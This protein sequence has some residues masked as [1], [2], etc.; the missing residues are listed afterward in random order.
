MGVP[1]N[2]YT[3]SHSDQLVATLAKQPVS[4]FETHYTKEVALFI[5]RHLNKA[6][7]WAASLYLRTIANGIGCTTR[8]VR[9]SLRRLESIGFFKTEFRKHD[10]I[11]NWNLASVYRIGSALLALFRPPSTKHPAKSLT[12]SKQKQSN[13][14]HAPVSSSVGKF[15]MFDHKRITKT[16]EEWEASKKASQENNR[17]ALQKLKEMLRAQR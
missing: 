17:N 14:D 10:Q 9:N 1:V 11:A 13:K 5:A 7:G 4:T 3:L 12:S 2:S 8:T 15:A 6:Q 16:Q